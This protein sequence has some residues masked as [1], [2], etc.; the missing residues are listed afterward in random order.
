MSASYSF[1][2]KCN[3]ESRIF[4]ESLSDLEQGGQ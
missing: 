2:R 3:G 4:D 1:F